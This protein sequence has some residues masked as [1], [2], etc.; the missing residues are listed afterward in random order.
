MQYDSSIRIV[1]VGKDAARY[2]PPHATNVQ[3]AGFVT[4]EEMQAILRSCI[5][6]ICPIVHG[7]GVKIKILDALAQHC[8]I[9]AT[10]E[11]LRGYEYFSIA[12]EVFMDDP[13]RTARSIVALA[14]QPEFHAKT[15]QHLAERMQDYLRFRSGK[16]VAIAEEIANHSSAR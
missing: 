3:A 7:S 9:I 1:L 14:T 16:L 10:A 15:K 4:G 8:P 6:L 11:S 13:E 12:P 5:A 2:I